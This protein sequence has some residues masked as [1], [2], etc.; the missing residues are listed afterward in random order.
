METVV[1][2]IEYMRRPVGGNQPALISA[3][4]AE[5]PIVLHA[6]AD[7]RRCTTPRTRETRVGQLLLELSVPLIVQRSIEAASK[8]AHR[9]S[10]ISTLKS[11]VTEATLA[12]VVSSPSI[13]DAAL[14]WNWKAS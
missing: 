14:G 12:L 10:P 6:T 1:A 2:N 11:P 9:P 7:N 8:T 5:A 3:V 13:G 4:R